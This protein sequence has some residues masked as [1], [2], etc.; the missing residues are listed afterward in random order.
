MSETKTRCIELI[1]VSTAG[2][3][4]ADRASIPAQRA[5]NRQTAA[6]YDLDIVRTI[7][8]ADVS[9]ANVLRSPEMQELLR[10][11]QEPQIGGVVAREF[12][13][14]M[15]PDNYDDLG[16]LQRFVDSRTDIYLPEGR[17]DPSDLLLTMVRAGVAGKERKEM[18]ERAWSAKEEKR[19]RGELAQSKIVLPFGVGYE[20]GKFYYKPE[21][22][23]VREAFRR[24][25][26]GEQNYS[27]LARYVGVTPRGMHVIMRN[28]IWTGWRVIDKKRDPSSAGRYSGQ[29]GRQADRRKIRRKEEDII[30]LQVIE[31]PLISE[32]DFAVVQELM[33]RKQARHWRS[34]TRQPRFIYTGFLTCSRCG[35]IIYSA[36][37]RNDYY[38]CKKRRLGHACET[39]YMKREKLEQILDQLFGSQLMDPAFLERCVQTAVSQRSASRSAHQIQRLTAAVHAL[40][41]KRERL[42]ESYVDGVIER[43]QRDS[44]LR[45]ID[46]DIQRA[47]DELMQLDGAS[48]LPEVRVLVDYFAALAE[49]EYWALEDKRRVLSTLVPN[50]RVADYQ[51]ESIGL[52]P[53]PFSYE[54]TRTDRDSSQPPA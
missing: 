38:I 17:V 45:T 21:A 5:V 28:H 19:K 41:K 31:E 35:E 36:K 26:A 27:T 22:E 43:S 47:Q 13:R 24:F 53:A 39:G 25:L 54:D 46:D 23:R 37:V 40:R 32:A 3:A 12:S 49:W 48:A 34:R 44:R 29:D 11:I 42:I 30:R 14:L 51:V 8:I 50:I 1:R 20:A 15:R 9:G 4:A 7:Q 18:L 10:L 6:R 2:Q 52:Q 16:L 33:N